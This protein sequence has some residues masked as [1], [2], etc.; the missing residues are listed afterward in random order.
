MPI[1][2]H[3]DLRTM[4]KHLPDTGA[5]PITDPLLLR[6][7]NCIPLAIAAL[8]DTVGAVTT[9]VAAS[10]GAT[11]RPPSSR[12]YR[13]VSELLQVQL[14]PCLSVDDLEEGKWLVH[15]EAAGTP[16]LHGPALQVQ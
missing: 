1:K 13:D 6:T 3:D 11:T 7:G 9:S 15:C 10:D 2:H 5:T 12:T 16:P 4:V 8:T 14:T